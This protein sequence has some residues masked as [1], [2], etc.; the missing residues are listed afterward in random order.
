[1]ELE[2][3]PR[4]IKPVDAPPAQAT[5][6]PHDTLT[7]ADRLEIPHM[8]QAPS[9]PISSR[10]VVPLPDQTAIVA[11]ETSKIIAQ[12]RNARGRKYAVALPRPRVE[13]GKATA[14]HN[15][16]KPVAEIKPCPSGVFDGLFR[17]LNLST[18]CQ[19]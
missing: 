12:K 18:R 11:E 19:T 5:V 7:T 15:R 10:E 17:A 8:L 14:K 13:H 3:P 9:Q 16:V 1:M 4:A 6:G 2:T